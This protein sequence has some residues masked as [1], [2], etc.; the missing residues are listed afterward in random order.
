MKSMLLFVFL[1]STWSLKAQTDTTQ[2]SK[3]DSAV[4]FMP[5]VEASYPGGPTYWAHYLNRNLVYPDLAM[6]KNI[7]GT[8]T[9]RFIVDTNGAVQNLTVIS[10]PKELCAE[11][12]RIIEHVDI[13]V[14]GTYNGKKVNSWKTQPITFKLERQ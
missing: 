5:D 8:V 11:T 3:G 6:Y 7:Q 13:W 4:Y 14:P 1:F 9:T 12:I 10:G 2:I